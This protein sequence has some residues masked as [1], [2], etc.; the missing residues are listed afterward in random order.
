MLLDEALDQENH[1]SIMWENVLIIQ[2]IFIKH[3]LHARYFTR[4]LDSNGDLT[5]E[6]WIQ[7]PNAWAPG[8]FHT[9]VTFLPNYIVDFLRTQLIPHRAS[10]VLLTEPATVSGRAF[11]ILSLRREGHILFS[12]RYRM[13]S[14]V[15]WINIYCA[16][17]FLSSISLVKK[18][19]KKSRSPHKE[20]NNQLLKEI[21]FSLF[22]E[23]FVRKA[24][25]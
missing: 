24:G 1:A 20:K 23:Y 16:I 17:Y 5:H 22:Q 14:I 19:K 11:R 25:G 15:E 2:Q 18:K 8:N 6:E 12:L 13:Y 10:S 9:S 4:H 3:M 21:Q 7:A